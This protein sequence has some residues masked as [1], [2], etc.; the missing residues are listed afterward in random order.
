MKKQIQAV[1]WILSLCLMASCAMPQKPASP[2]REP[3]QTT[4]VAT[5]MDSAWEGA[6]RVMNERCDLNYAFSVVPGQIKNDGRRSNL[7]T[8]M[9]CCVQ[10]LR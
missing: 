4:P 5:C 2:S 6:G 7:E 9:V 3:A 1:F 10:K 8:V